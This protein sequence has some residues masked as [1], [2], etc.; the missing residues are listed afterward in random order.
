M[1]IEELAG[2][3]AFRTAQH[4]NNPTASHIEVT[5]VG[6]L[7][8]NNFVPARRS[9]VACMC[10]TEEEAADYVQQQPYGS[11]YVFN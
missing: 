1:R 7:T 10:S 8:S 4:T 6:H 9:Y 5:Y 2:V 11:V 3:Y